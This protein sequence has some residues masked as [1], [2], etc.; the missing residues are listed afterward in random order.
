MN[1]YTEI[2]ELADIIRRRYDL[3]K[4]IMDFI[5]MKTEEMR[6]FKDGDIVEVISHDGKYK[7]DGI[8]DGAFSWLLRSL[9]DYQI[10]EYATDLGKYEKTLYEIR[11]KVKA[12]KKDGTKSER[13]ADGRSSYSGIPTTYNY[14]IRLKQ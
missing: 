12:I 3:R 10:L 7:C 1:K 11:Y 4:E 13:N 2:K 8:I 9:E 14:H 5:Q 6:V